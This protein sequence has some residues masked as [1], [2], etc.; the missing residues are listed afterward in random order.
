MNQYAYADLTSKTT[1]VDD[2]D[3]NSTGT[4]SSAGTYVAA[5]RD[6]V[7]YGAGQFICLIDNVGAVPTQAPRRFQQ[8]KWSPLVIVRS[9]P[10]V[11][12]SGS[13][14]T[15]LA[16]NGTIYYNFLGPRF[17]ETTFDRNVMI[18]A[19]N[20]TPGAEVTVV[21]VS[22]GSQRPV[23]YDAQFSWF[24][25]QVPFTS[26]TSNQKILVQLASTGTVATKVLGETQ[27]QV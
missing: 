23:A 5:T 12:V 9:T 27:S 10:S 6:V 13:I 4:W 26:P 24:G 21:L 20:F 14:P 25:T 15:G 1:Y 18:S 3:I 7:S 17:V 16:V 11:E 2:G 19:K 8:P 22:N